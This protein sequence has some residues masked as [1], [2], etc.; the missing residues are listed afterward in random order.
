[1]NFYGG[2][3]GLGDLFA[4]NTDGTG[5]TDL[6]SLYVNNDDPFPNGGLIQALDGRLYGV[7]GGAVQSG[8]GNIF[9]LDADGTGF[10]MVYNFTAGYDGAF[11]VGPLLQGADGRLYGIDATGAGVGVS[12]LGEAPGNIF[13][14]NTDGTGFAIVH[15]FSASTEGSGSNCGLIQGTDGRLYGVAVQGGASNDGTV[16]AVNPDGTGFTVLYTFTGANDGKYPVYSLLQMPD[17]SIVGAAQAGGAGGAG[18]LF[19]IGGS[20]YSAGSSVT[21]SVA[22]TGTGPLSCHW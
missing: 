6:I 7:A 5:Y 9:A 4:I 22:A 1:V 15:S 10:S 20:V 18:T 17:G 3:L 8:P 19:S 13:A 2:N 12:P 21:Y 16:Y 14:V 11:P